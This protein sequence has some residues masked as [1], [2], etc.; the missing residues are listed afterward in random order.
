MRYFFRRI[1]SC[2]GPAMEGGL[3]KYSF[4]KREITRIRKFLTCDPVLNANEIEVMFN[5]LREVERQYTQHQTKL[6][7]ERHREY[8]V[9]WQRGK[10]AGDK[11]RLEE[12]LRGLKSG[13]SLMMK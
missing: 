6:A 12:T 10:Y 7:N 4:S 9:N 1:N 13:S 11:L 8:K 2:L 3:M 5:G